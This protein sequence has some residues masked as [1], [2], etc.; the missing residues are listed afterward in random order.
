[1]L[2]C[3]TDSI[4]KWSMRFEVPAKR[5]VMINSFMFSLDLVVI[6]SS[7]KGDQ[8]FVLFSSIYASPPAYLS[9]FCFYC[10]SQ[11]TPASIEPV[12]EI[13]EYSN[14]SS[15]L[16]KSECHPVSD[17]QFSPVHCSPRR[18]VLL[19]TMLPESILV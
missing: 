12:G 4:G 19:D 9:I 7:N 1:M 2:D 8:V 17:E 15:P 5:Y 11:C 18:I 3:S 6:A 14:R 10:E 13:S 16:F